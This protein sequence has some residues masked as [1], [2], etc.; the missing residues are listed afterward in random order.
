MKYIFIL[1]ISLFVFSGCAAKNHAYDDFEK[2]P[3]ACFKDIGSE[4]ENV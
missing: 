4:V 2:S 1:I 3:C